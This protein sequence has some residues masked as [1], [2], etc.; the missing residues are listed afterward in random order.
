MNHKKPKRIRTNR[1]LTGRWAGLAD[2]SLIW[3]TFLGHNVQSEQ[4]RPPKWKAVVNRGLL[5]R[6]GPGREIC[7][8][9]LNGEAE[10]AKDIVGD[11]TVQSEQSENEM[12]LDRCECP[13]RE[14]L[15]F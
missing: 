1:L 10:L 7:L 9:R 14:R 12:G 4:C 2:W 5:G 11:T 15:S 3:N 6:S 13:K 8:N